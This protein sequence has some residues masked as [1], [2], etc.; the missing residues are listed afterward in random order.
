MSAPPVPPVFREIAAAAMDMSDLELLM[1]MGSV[2]A[3]LVERMGSERVR[4]SME[5]G[6]KAAEAAR[7]GRKAGG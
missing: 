5:I 7:A 4:E 3:V 1:V 2:L 6:I